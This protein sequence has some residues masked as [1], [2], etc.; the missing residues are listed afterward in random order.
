VF[1]IS[2][3]SDALRRLMLS[4]SSIETRL[5]SITPFTLPGITEAL[6]SATVAGL[7]NALY[8]EIDRYCQDR[9]ESALR[10]AVVQAREHDGFG[11]WES[12]VVLQP[13]EA[14]GI[15][16]NTLPQRVC[17]LTTMYLLIDQT[18]FREYRSR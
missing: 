4:G 17:T 1:L 18:R 12:D 7:N 3:N 2:R 11:V 13:K 9:K 5:D 6:A 10:R 16:K 15:C 14:L 8:Q